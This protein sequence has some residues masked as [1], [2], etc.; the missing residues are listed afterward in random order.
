MAKVRSRARALP[1]PLLQDWLNGILTCTTG[2]WTL[3]TARNLCNPSR[4]NPTPPIAALIVCLA[5]ATIP[6]QSPC[7]DGGEIDILCVLKNL[8]FN[9]LTLSAT[10]ALRVE[11]C[12]SQ[13]CFVTSVNR[14]S[15]GSH[16]SEVIV[17]GVYARFSIILNNNCL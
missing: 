17:I 9:S 7:L 13:T 14:I 1:N 16:T 4:E 6:R 11:T 12:S 10:K 2:L 8:Y 5:Q 15:L 3:L